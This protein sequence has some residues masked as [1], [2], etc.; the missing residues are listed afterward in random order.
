MGH[1]QVDGKWPLAWRAC[2]QLLWG[3][4]ICAGAAMVIAGLVAAGTTEIED[5]VYIDRGYENVVEKFLSSVPISGA[6]R[7]S[8]YIKLK[9][10]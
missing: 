8:E 3:R 1:I 9:R 5:V 2:V 7:R 6:F 10:A 4:L